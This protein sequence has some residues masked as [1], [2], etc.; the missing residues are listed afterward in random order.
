[1]TWALGVLAMARSASGSVTLSGWPAS[2]DRVIMS[3]G[4]CPAPVRFAR[5]GLTSMRAGTMPER[6][7]PLS[8]ASVG[9]WQPCLAGIGTSLPKAHGLT[10]QASTLVGRRSE[11][12]ARRPDS[13]DTS[14]GGWPSGA[15]VSGYRAQVRAL[16]SVRLAREASGGMFHGFGCPLASI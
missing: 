2:T 5:S 10:R 12:E 1:M 9:G 8:E 14:C 15:M 4:D 3:R 16:L 7:T 13:P 6:A 11:T